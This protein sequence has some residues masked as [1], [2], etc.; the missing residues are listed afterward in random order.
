MMIRTSQLRKDY[1]CVR[2]YTFGNV[3]QALQGALLRM[4][5][6]LCVNTI[7][8]TDLKCNCSDLTCLIREGVTSHRW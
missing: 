5:L 6:I 8:H 3:E 4:F 1:N 7:V 2:L